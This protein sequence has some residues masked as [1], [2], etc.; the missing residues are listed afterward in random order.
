M[1]FQRADVMPHKIG[2]GERGGRGGLAFK[3]KR[4]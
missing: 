3:V 1:R 2:I 4:G